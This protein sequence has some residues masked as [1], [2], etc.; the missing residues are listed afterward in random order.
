MT[1]ELQTCI[2]MFKNGSACSQ[3]IL[4]V[5]GPEMG[6]DAKT[7]HKLGTGLGAGYGRKQY[8]CGAVSAGILLLGLKY[9]NEQPGDVE[10]KNNTYTI[11]F[12][13]VER[14]EQKLGCID[15]LGLLGVSIKTDK[16]LR[17]AVGKGVFSER[18]TDIISIV[19]G[20]LD[21]CI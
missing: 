16:E 1:S 10:K 4:A 13:F 18:C 2:G 11:V 6:L 3:A 9:G 12:N 14:I 15:C 5:Y 7:A 17:E 19:T 20:E 8:T 21:R